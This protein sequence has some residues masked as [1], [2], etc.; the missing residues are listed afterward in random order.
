MAFGII[1]HYLYQQLC[2]ENPPQLLMIIHEQGGTGKTCLLQA[3]TTL[4]SDMQCT[5]MLAKTALS[6]V[7]ASQIG[8]KTIHS[9]A[10]IP[11]GKGLPCS[12]SWIFAAALIAQES[13]KRTCTANFSLHVTK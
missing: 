12:D 11:A 2:G 6:G 8:G 9:W 13:T 10:T 7:A 1:S 3:I 5:N 4:F